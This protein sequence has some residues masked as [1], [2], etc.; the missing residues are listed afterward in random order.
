[1]LKYKFD[2]TISS[3]IIPF[4]SSWYFRNPFCMKYLI[5][6][7]HFGFTPISPLS[8]LFTHRHTEHWHWN[9]HSL[10][11]Y[12][13]WLTSTDWTVFEA[14]VYSKFSW[15]FTICTQYSIGELCFTICVLCFIISHNLNPQKMPR[16][17]FT[18][19]KLILFQSIN[20]LHWTTLLIRLISN[21]WWGKINLAH[22]AT[23][24]EYGGCVHPKML[25]HLFSFHFGERTDVLR[26]RLKG[27]HF[28]TH[29]SLTH[30]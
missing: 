7:L 9:T 17:Y 16:H 12:S 24:N 27:K 1:M 11:L 10:T 15:K 14:F 28:T 23:V 3:I 2:F 25:F 22:K 29:T 18:A 8:L 4:F 20:T 21:I 26:F 30:N 6:G 5:K 13:H 19:P